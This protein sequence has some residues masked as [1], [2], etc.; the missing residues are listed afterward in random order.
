V[1]VTLL[2]ATGKVGRPVLRELL[3]RGHEPIAVARDVGALTPEFDGLALLS[4]DIF[5]PE[6]LLGTLAG[7]DVLISSVALRDDAQRDRTPVAM[8][9]LIVAAAGTAQVRWISLGGAGSLEIQPGLQL[10]DSDAFPPA[11]R[12]ESQGFRDALHELRATGG[13]VPDALAWTVISPPIEIVID[14][15]RTGRYRTGGDQLMRD[16]AGRS[17]ISVDDLAVAVVDE[18]ESG[19][20]PRQRFSVAY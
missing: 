17:W 9:R 16:D 2:G 5:D 1:R 4:G 10:V 20:H 19:A 18:M 12:K 15:E 3:R 11:A 8:T 14:A 6:F 7:S 13:I